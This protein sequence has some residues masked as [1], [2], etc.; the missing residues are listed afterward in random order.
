M[1]IL[2]EEQRAAKRAQYTAWAKAN[3]EKVRARNARWAKAN[4]QKRRAWYLRRY[5]AKRAQILKRN[6][7][8]VKTHHTEIRRYQA[9]WHKQ[10]PEKVREI[11][12]RYRQVNRE[13]LRKRLAE[14]YARNPE[15]F[16]QKALAWRQSNPEKVRL[17]WPIIAINRDKI[18][19]RRARR[20]AN[21]EKS[22]A[23]CALRRARKMEATI[24]EKTCIAK[25]YALAA[26]LRKA[27][28]D[29]EV[30]HIIALANGG[31]HAEWNLQIIYASE[32][33]A[34]GDRL[35]YVPTRIF[36][37]ADLLVTTAGD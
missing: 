17:S 28:F 4:P 11:N 3:P 25:I 6:A 9:Q 34:K 21:P 10:N 5:N 33:A 27:G 2:T 22:R 36:T 37:E 26:E 18:E 13:K 12:V 24:G 14:R 30:D 20:K 32:N 1:R 7:E 31:A 16:N 15:K 35:D 19:D 23:D 8:Y 29:V